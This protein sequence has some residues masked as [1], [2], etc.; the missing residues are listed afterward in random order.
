ML[1][2]NRNRMHKLMSLTYHNRR[3]TKLLLRSVVGML[4]QMQIP[5]VARSKTDMVAFPVC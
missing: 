5:P 1:K 2:H 4:L 3:L